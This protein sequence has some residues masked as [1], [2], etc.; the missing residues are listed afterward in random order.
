MDQLEPWARLWEGSV[1]AAFLGAYH[2]TVAPVGL[3][4]ES[5][6]GT[7]A[8]LRAYLLDK[9]FYELLYE[10]NHRPAWVR[11]PLWGLASL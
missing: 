9:A 11:I 10:L 1:A 7:E 5:Q 6:A 2:E 4:P 3:L 8:L